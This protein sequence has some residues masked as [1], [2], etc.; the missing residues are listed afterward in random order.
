VLR[1]GD[2]AVVGRTERGRCLLDLRCIRPGDD[3]MV[4]AAIRAAARRLAGDG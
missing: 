2:P 4:P 3:L 1:T